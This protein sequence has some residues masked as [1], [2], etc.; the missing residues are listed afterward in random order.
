MIQL[1]F[2]CKMTVPK[3]CCTV[4]IHFMYSTYT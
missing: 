4:R 2:F 1:F 3:I